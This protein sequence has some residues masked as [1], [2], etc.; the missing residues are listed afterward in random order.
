VYFKGLV[1]QCETEF[2]LDTGV[3]GQRS[4]KDDSSGSRSPLKNKAR[5]VAPKTNHS[6]QHVKQTQAQ[7]DSFPGGTNKRTNYTMLTWTI[8]RSMDLLALDLNRRCKH[9][10]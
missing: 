2:A 10:W 6:A 3:T 8:I 7:L 4:P 5:F 9:G 1:N